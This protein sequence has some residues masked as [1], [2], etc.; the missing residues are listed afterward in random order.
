MVPG[1][2][3]LLVLGARAGLRRRGARLARGERAAR[4]AP[5]PLL[6]ARRRPA[7]ARDRA[8]LAA[9]AL[10]GRVGSDLLAARARRPGRDR[11]RA[12]A[13]R[14]GARSRGRAAAG[15]RRLRRPDRLG[16]P[17]PRHRGAAPALSRPAARGRGPL[18]PGLLRARRRLRPGGAAHPRRAPG[19]RLRR[20][21]PEGV[22]QLRRRRRLVLP[23]LPH[24]AR[25]AEAPRPEPA[26]RR[27]EEPGHHRTP[28]EADHGRRG[29]LGGLLRGRA[30]A[31]R[32]DGGRARRRLADR[33]GYPRAR[34]RPGVDLHLPAPDPAEP[35]ATGERRARAPGRAPGARGPGIPPAA[36]A[37]AHRGGAAP[38]GRLP[39]P[40]AP[41]AHGAAG[42]G[43]LDREGARQRDRPAPS[44]AG[45]GGARAV[46]SARRRAPPRL[47]LLPLGD[48]HG[49]DLRD[50]TQRDRP[51]HPRAAAVTAS[52]RGQPPE[53]SPLRRWLA[54]P[55]TAFVFG[56][57]LVVVLARPGGLLQDP[58]TGWHLVTGRYIL[59]TGT[60]PA[61]D[62]F[63]FTAAGHEWINYCWLFEVASAILVS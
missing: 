4:L 46:G 48:D 33:D 63:S 1:G 57:H 13:L 58:G 12:L 23:P 2:R 18:V 56:L 19:R 60:I 9:E 43:E 28:L 27:H 29:V 51:A 59:E 32:D 49:R 50:P 5:R 55:F 40:D 6:V 15:R 21:R 24:R 44:G 36:R 35:R 20:E 42:C 37:G 30:R 34:A 11:H 22:D 26:P 53:P 61:C 3:E 10:R 14:R 31:G 47:P 39:E 54:P 62:L 38:P 16:H 17:P 45:D 52:T 25:G 41:P 8:R 7:L